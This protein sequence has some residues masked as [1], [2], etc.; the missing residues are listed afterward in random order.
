MT[1]FAGTDTV[2]TRT[3]QA[4]RDAALL[5]ENLLAERTAWERRL[6]DDKRS[7]LLKQVTGRS[8]LDAAIDS[9]RRMLDTLDRTLAEAEGGARAR[10]GFSIAPELVVLGRGRG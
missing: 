7:D 9:T 6:A 3:R 1:T 2:L 4:R 10:G 8:S 5:L